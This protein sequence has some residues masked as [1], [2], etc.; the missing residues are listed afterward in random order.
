MSDANPKGFILKQY[1]NKFYTELLIKFTTTTLTM[2]KIGYTTQIQYVNSL[3][4]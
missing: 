4:K 3:I 1:G 2:V